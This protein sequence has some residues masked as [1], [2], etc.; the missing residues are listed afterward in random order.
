MNENIAQHRGGFT[1]LE[2]LAAVFILITAAGL[3]LT[4]VASVGKANARVSTRHAACQEAAGALERLGV[5]PFEKLEETAKANSIS[6]SNAFSRRVKEPKLEIAVTDESQPP[7]GTLA[8][9]VVVTIDWAG[10]DGRPVR[11]TSWRFVPEPKAEPDAESDEKG[12]DEKGS[13]EKEPAEEEMDANS[14]EP[15]SD[16]KAEETE[17]KSETESETKEETP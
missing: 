14:N 9:R 11:L 5:V 16:S 6:L 15:P 4:A 17:K 1:L 3:A 13:D 7:E 8:K 10:S 12:S 2:I